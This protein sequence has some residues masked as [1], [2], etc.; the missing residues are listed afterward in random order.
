MQ[1]LD[2]ICNS[3]CIEHWAVLKTGDVPLD[4][5]RAAYSRWFD[6]GNG[7]ALK[8]IDSRLDIIC[9]PFGHRPWAKSAIVIAFRPKM[10]QDSPLRQ[11]PPP[12]PGGPVATIAEYALN[13]DYHVTGQRILKSISEALGENQFECCVDSSPVPEKELLRLAGIGAIHTPNSLA[14]VK[15]CG[16]RVHIGVLF[17]SLDLPSCIRDE[18]P[19]CGDC[20]ACLSICPNHAMTGEGTIRVRQCRSWLASEWHGPLSK[21]QQFMLHNT[22]FGCSLCSCCCPDERHGCHDLRVNPFAVMEMPTAELRRITTTTPISH[23]SPSLLK[24][25]AA[26]AI[27]TQAH[28]NDRHALMEKL[29]PMSASPAVRDTIAAWR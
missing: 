22:L 4:Y 25:N 2:D 16:C 21:E 1:Q 18:A 20:H 28:E 6:A 3:L 14:R 5:L 26:A 17:T 8:Y 15:G 29:L 13:E 12:E 23:I 9:D 27:L 19:Q 24:R 10:I 11:L 7:G